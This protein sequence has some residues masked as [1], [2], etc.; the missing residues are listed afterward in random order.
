MRLRRGVGGGPEQAQL[1]HKYQRHSP[2]KHGTQI[3]PP[4]QR[5]ERHAHHAER[6]QHGWQI[7]LPVLA[8][9]QAG[10]DQQ[11]GNGHPHGELHRMEDKHPEIQPQQ[12]GVLQHLRHAAARPVDVVQRLGRHPPQHDGNTAQ[13]QRARQGKQAVQ[14]D[15][16]R[17]QRRNH[18]RQGKHQGN[19]GADQRH[20][21]GT[22][23]VAGGI[24]Q[25]G[26]DRGRNGPGALQ[27][28]AGNQPVQ[29]WRPGG[30]KA[31]QR[32]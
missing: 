22:H 24:R 16:T 8:L 1:H 23:L 4:F 14:P 18:Q 20:G 13:R 27:R 15:V 28:T 3:A 26:R 19:A 10:G 29:V 11:G 21:L 6:S 2:Q 31:A 7:N 12:R 17:Q 9:V 32:E 25:Q 30:H 5:E